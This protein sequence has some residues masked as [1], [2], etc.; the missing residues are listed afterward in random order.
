[1]HGDDTLQ[2]KVLAKRYEILQP[3]GQGAVAEVYEARDLE[4]KELV[5]VKVLK[6]DHKSDAGFSERLIQ[7]ARSAARI[8][9]PH[10]VD[11]FDVGQ[12]EDGDWFFVMER[13]SGTDLEHVLLGRGSLR[14]EDACEIVIQCCEALQAAHT[15]GIVHRDLKPSNILLT[16][17]AG[18]SDFVKIIDF[19]VAKN[20]PS[21]SLG[22]RDRKDS[23][24][25]LIV[26]TAE[27]M[28][29]EQA[30]A[31]VVDHRSDIYALG[32]IFYQMLTGKPPFV[33]NADIDV[34]HHHINSPVPSV[35]EALPHGA[36]SMAMEQIVR[37]ALAKKPEDRFQSM[38][39]LR[40]AVAFALYE[41]R[42]Q[43]EEASS[44]LRAHMREHAKKVRGPETLDPRRSKWGAWIVGGLCLALLVL[45]I[46]FAFH[47]GGK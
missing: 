16:E 35:R 27:Y 17:R 24:K 6:A 23:V 28:S 15:Q 33:A 13:L 12:S 19:G 20:L 34:I 45:G 1:M 14:A 8:R 18:Q 25:N 21:A 5:A 38:Q 26:G 22:I 43:A 29:P 40:E 41:T 11:I 42:D 31:G 37:R 39:S 7:E 2:G 46:W 47:R 44:S 3:L 32:A 4:T 30:S 36:V 9:H 10:I